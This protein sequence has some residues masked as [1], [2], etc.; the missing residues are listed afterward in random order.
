MKNAIILHGSSCNPNSFWQPSIKKFLQKKGYNVW[1]PQLPNA[2]RP[3]LK[4]Q[5]SFILG[6]GIYF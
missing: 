3:D 1:V 2:D 4:E 5:L 6:G